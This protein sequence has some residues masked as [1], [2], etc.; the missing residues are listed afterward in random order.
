MKLNGIIKFE[1]L[2]DLAEFLG[3]MQYLGMNAKFNVE[4][5]GIKY[6]LRFE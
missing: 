5:D 6:I 4:H 3:E 2:H 1:N